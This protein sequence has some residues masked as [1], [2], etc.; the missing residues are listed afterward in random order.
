MEGLT[1]NCD[2]YYRPI[3]LTQRVPTA[4]PHSLSAWGLIS[5]RTIRS[6]R[7]Y[8]RAVT[9]S[10]GFT[11]LWISFERPMGPETLG[12]HFDRSG[13]PPSGASLYNLRRRLE[14]APGQGEGFGSLRLLVQKL[15]SSVVH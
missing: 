12:I 13:P 3:P 14:Y 8:R 4:F 1:S 9:I 15:L 7:K 11:G 10:I 5:Q 2:S 6:A